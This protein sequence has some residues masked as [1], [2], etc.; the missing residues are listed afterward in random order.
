MGL[1]FR[2]FGMVKSLVAEQ[3]KPMGYAV[4]N[5]DD[6]MTVE[7]AKKAFRFNNLF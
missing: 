2:G 7:V 1:F 6:S 5:T 3:V 4:L